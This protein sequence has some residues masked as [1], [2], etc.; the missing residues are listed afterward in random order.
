LE[1]K[2]ARKIGIIGVPGAG[3]TT[4]AK[5][6]Q[7]HIGSVNFTTA[8]CSEYAREYL[9]KHGGIEHIAIQSSILFKQMRR[10]DILSSSCDL[11]F[12]D[13]PI[14]FCWLYAVLQLDPS[15]SEQRKIVRDLYKWA[16]LDQLHRYD[17]IIFLPRQF[18]VVDDGCRDPGATE[19]IERTLLGFLDSHSHLFPRFVKISS[20]KVDPQDILE[21]RVVQIYRYLHDELQ[22]PQ[23]RPE[24]ALA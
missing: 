22:V 16:V 17:V 5:A 15:S 11:L 24:L 8:A 19:I 6:L 12:S 10:E 21:D 4:L 7:V 1:Q 13:S 9:H 3:K 20:E 23:I 18:D 14:F 2:S